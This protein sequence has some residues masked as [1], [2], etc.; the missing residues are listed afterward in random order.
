MDS[1]IYYTEYAGRPIYAD[2]GKFIVDIISYIFLGLAVLGVIGAII[3]MIILIK[4]TKKKGQTYV[5]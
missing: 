3:Y 2:G 1:S 4:S 5:T